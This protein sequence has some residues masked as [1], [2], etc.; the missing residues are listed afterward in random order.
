MFVLLFLGLY[1]LVNFVHES[2]KFNVVVGQIVG[3]EVKKKLTIFFFEFL[4]F[5]GSYLLLN[6]KLIS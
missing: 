5:F 2:Y 4:Y 3:Q 6:I 1:L